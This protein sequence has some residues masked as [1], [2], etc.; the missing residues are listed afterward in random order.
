MG[1][2]RERREESR[3]SYIYQLTIEGGQDKGSKLLNAGAGSA[4]WAMASHSIAR[5]VGSHFLGRRVSGSSGS[6]AVCDVVIPLPKNA[7]ALSSESTPNPF[8]TL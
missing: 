4:S 2:L 5:P 6:V 8:R 7:I 3:D 1:K